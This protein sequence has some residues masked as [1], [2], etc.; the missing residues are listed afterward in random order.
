MAGGQDM[1]GAAS[2]ETIALKKLYG[3]VTMGDAWS[4]II[5]KD[6]VLRKIYIG[7][8]SNGELEEALDKIIGRKQ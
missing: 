4:F 8:F 1:L 2:E 3:F 7:L 5:D 6:G